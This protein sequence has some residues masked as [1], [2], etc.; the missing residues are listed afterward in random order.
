MPNVHADQACRWKF[1]QPVGLARPA[2]V[3]SISIMKVDAG[4][5]VD[6]EVDEDVDEEVDG[7]RG[8]SVGVMRRKAQSAKYRKNCK[9]EHRHH[10]TC[11]CKS[12]HAVAT[13]PSWCLVLGLG[14]V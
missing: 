1:S 3:S 11:M 7:D 9:E 4:G 6:E 5:E 8:V 13:F 2:I 14:L 12:V 10:H